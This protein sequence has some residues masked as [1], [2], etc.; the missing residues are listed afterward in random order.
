MFEIGNVVIHSGM[1]VCR[2]TE[3]KEEQIAKA[4]RKFYVLSPLY[5]NTSTKIFIPTDKA[6]MLLRL[7][8][9]KADVLSALNAAQAEPTLWDEQDNLRKE[10]FTAII[11]SADHA[12]IIHLLKEL[13]EKRR[14]K[15]SIG[16]KLRISDEKLLCEAERIIH[17][18]LAYTMNIAI[19]E[20]RDFIMENIY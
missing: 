7:P 6:E 2:I 11:K 1:G 20:I 12:K 8:L 10:K 13:H 16:K 17:Q 5:E 19:D 3:I 18:E 4:L 15:E 9:T 14:E